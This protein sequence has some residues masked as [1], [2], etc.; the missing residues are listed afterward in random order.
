MLEAIR[1]GTT[2]NFGQTWELNPVSQ[3]ERDWLIKQLQE[4]AYQNLI[5]VSFL[6]GDVSCAAV[7][8]FKTYARSNV[9]HRVDHRYMVNVVTSKFWRLD[10]PEGCL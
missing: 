3:L 10:L 8:V 2:S 1:F 6:S 7:G 4:F 5:R 9:S